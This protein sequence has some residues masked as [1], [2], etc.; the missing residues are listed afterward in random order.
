[1]VQ[2]IIEGDVTSALLFIHLS[3]YLIHEWIAY[4]SIS[5][6]QATV[7]RNKFQVNINIHVSERGWYFFLFN[8]H[9]YVY[10]FDVMLYGCEYSILQRSFRDDLLVIAVVVVWDLR[11]GM[12]R[13]SIYARSKLFCFYH[14]FTRQ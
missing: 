2:L 11:S 8:A 13:M 6:T 12:M 14:L 7:K 5:E 9:I 3:F 4:T 1:M 10:H